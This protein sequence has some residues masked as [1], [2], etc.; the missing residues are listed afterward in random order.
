MSIDGDNHIDEVA[1]YLDVGF[2]RQ[3]SSCSGEL[4]YS[5]QSARIVKSLLLKKFSA[6]LPS[7]W[8][9]GAAGSAL[10]WHG[11]GRRFDPDQVHQSQPFP[12][13]ADCAAKAHRHGCAPALFGIYNF[14]VQEGAAMS[15]QLRIT[16][17]E[18][19][20]RMESG[21]HF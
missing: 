19:K 1:G 10:P 15:S 20:R 18:L 14:A 3:V 13:I 8:A 5:A 12:C 9:C 11:R 21:E 2:S 7:M 17:D 6:S 16:V 4:T